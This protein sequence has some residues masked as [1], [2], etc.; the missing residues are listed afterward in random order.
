MLLRRDPHLRRGALET[1]LDLMIE[2][3][4]GVEDPDGDP[5]GRR[6]PRRADPAQ[7]R[8]R[9]ISHIYVGVESTQQST[10]DLYH[11]D[12]KVNESKKA[13]DLIQPARQW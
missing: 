8:H 1:I 13:I 5:G 4:T 12:I 2:R 7:V 10:L 9:R 3:K 6:D 11:K